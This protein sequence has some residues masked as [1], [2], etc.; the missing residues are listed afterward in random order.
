MAS[1]AP[2]VIECI[3]CLAYGTIFM[4]AMFRPKIKLNVFPPPRNADEQWEVVHCALWLMCFYKY[5][6]TTPAVGRK[7]FAPAHS[8]FVDDHIHTF[9]LHTNHVSKKIVVE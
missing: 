4:R 7:R 9:I 8:L 3:D 6:Q 1:I 2:I 5:G